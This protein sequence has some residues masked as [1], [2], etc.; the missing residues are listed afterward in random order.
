MVLLCRCQACEAHPELF[1]YAG[2]QGGLYGVLEPLR[3][4]LAAHGV[5][6]NTLLWFTSDN[7]PH[8]GEVGST[9][10]LVDVRSATNGLR[11]CKASMWE[12]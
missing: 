10:R 4:M 3:A 8:Q 11:Q 5:G 7:G 1:D 6:H 12:V 2:G 9:E